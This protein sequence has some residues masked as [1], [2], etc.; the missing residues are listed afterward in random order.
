VKGH[1]PKIPLVGDA[2][3]TA[4]AGCAVPKD[5]P[6]K[7]ESRPEISVGR[8]PKPIRSGQRRYLDETVLGPLKEVRSGTEIEVRIEQRMGVMLDAE[9]IPSE[10]EVECKARPHFPVIADI[11]RYLIEAIAAAE[12]W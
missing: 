1:V 5:V 3:T 10:A 11:A 9:V 7:P 12:L 6:G 2:P 4:Q 8:L